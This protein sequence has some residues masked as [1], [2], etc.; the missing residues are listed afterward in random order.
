MVNIVSGDENKFVLTVCT[1]IN[2]IVVM[3]LQDILF[4]FLYAFGQLFCPIKL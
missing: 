3:S 4:F 1:L 2:F